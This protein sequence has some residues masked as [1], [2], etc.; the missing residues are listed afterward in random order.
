[1]ERIDLEQALSAMPE[2]WSPRVV[3]QV[4]ETDVKL[5]KLA[6]AFEWHH[7][8]REDELFLV[9]KGRLV[10]HLRERDVELQPGQMLVVPRGVEHKPE[11][12]EECWVML[13]EP[14]TTLRRGN[15]ES[16]EPEP[17]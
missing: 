8:A 14:R 6:G 10:M 2:L 4:N 16:A 13:V 17:R 7:H 3:A 12:P 15:L 9:L 5:V 1:M 11:A